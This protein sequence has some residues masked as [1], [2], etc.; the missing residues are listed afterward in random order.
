MNELTRR[1]PQF[2]VRT[3]ERSPS[4]SS[5]PL[6]LVT[7]SSNTTCQGVHDIKRRELRKII[8]GVNFAKAL[9]AWR[10]GVGGVLETPVR[11]RGA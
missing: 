11:D 10:S 2:V 4:F 5:E 7:S 1:G 6:S 8:F 9:L 3:N